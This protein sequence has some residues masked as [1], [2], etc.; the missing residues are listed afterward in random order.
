MT[1]ATPSDLTGVEKAAILLI[2]LGRDKSAEVLSQLSPDEVQRLSQIMAQIPYVTSGTRDTVIE[3]VAQ[4][5]GEECCEGGVDYVR[6]VLEKALGPQK[7]SRVMDGMSPEQR[8]RPLESLADVAGDQLALALRGEH[9]QTIALVLCHLPAEKAA[10][11]LGGLPSDQQGE[12]AARIAASDPPAAEVAEQLE[13]ALK[14]R[15]AGGGAAGATTGGRPP[16]PFGSVKKPSI[17]ACAACASS[18]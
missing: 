10:A 2:A 5:V 1:T 12:V 15:L 16:G 14:A 13:R 8:A 11:V 7:A 4:R 18:G 3:E 6:Q 9:P 17:S